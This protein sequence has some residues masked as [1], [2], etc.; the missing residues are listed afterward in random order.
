M[1]IRP[2]EIRQLRI[3]H[4]LTQRNL[5]DSLYGVKRE[6][7]TDWETGRRD[8]PALVAWA[9]IL[10]WDKLDIREP[11]QLEMWEDKYASL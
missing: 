5:A 7:V 4:G 2:N 3:R 11:K 1:K 10:E 6:R 9:M 8:Y